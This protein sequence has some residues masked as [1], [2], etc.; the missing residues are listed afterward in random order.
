[1]CT[2]GRGL[3]DAATTRHQGTMRAAAPTAK[4]TRGGPYFGTGT[5]PRL[6][7]YIRNSP[8]AAPRTFSLPS[9]PY[10]SS[11]LQRWSDDAG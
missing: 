11:R 10:Q 8:D 4:N 9:W 2:P 7:M 5:G 1:M 3:P 6:S